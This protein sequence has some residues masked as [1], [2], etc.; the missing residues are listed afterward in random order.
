MNEQNV[1][2]A[3]A[4]MERVRDRGDKLDMTEWQNVDDSGHFF[5]N[6]ADVRQCGTACC[7][8]GW[9]AVSPE[10]QSQ[11]GETINSGCPRYERT[12]GTTAIAKFLNIS[13]ELA[14]VLCATDIF[15]FQEFYA[16]DSIGDIT[17]QMVIDKLNLILKGELS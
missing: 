8:A 16:V 15:G 5:E 17:P 14:S 13:Y 9:L 6:E 2:A 11:G 3:I 1:K 12:N 10:F 7:F 4:V